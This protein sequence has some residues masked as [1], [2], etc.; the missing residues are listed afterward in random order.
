MYKYFQDQSHLLLV[1]ANFVEM[2]SDE[3][4]NGGSSEQLGQALDQTVKRILEKQ[5]KP[6][7]LTMVR[8]QVRSMVV[9]IFQQEIGP[10]VEDLIRRV[11]KEV[12]QEHVEVRPSN[13]GTRNDLPEE[14]SLQLKFVYDQVSD[15][16][17]GQELKGINNECL[18]LALV[19]SD[20]NIVTCGSGSDAK[21]EILLLDDNG[22][23]G[24]DNISLENFER[25]IIQTGEKK[26][27]HFAKSVYKSLKEGIAD[28]NDL[29]LGHDKDRIKK[30]SCRLGA[31]IM[32]NLDRTTVLEAWTA[33][34]T[35][36]DKHDKYNDK[37]PCPSL[38]S[39]V[40]RLEGIGRNGKPCD[41]LKNES[42]KTVQDFLFWFHVNPEKLQKKILCVGDCKWK[43]IVSHAQ[44][45]NIDCKR[46][47]SHKSSTEPQTCVIYD[48]VG[49]L[50]GSIVESHF[51]PIDDMPSDEKDR[52]RELLRYVLE[53]PSAFVE[54]YASSLEDEGSLLKKFPY[55]SLQ[56]SGLTVSEDMNGNHTSSSQS[57]IAANN[58]YACG[59][60]GS[61]GSIEMGE[62]SN[63][64]AFPTDLHTS[65]Y[66]T[67]LCFENN[68]SPINMLVSGND[69]HTAEMGGGSSSGRSN[70]SFQSARGQWADEEL[71]YPALLSPGQVLA[72]FNSHNA[73][74]WLW[75][76]EELPHCPGSPSSDPTLYH[77]ADVETHN[78]RAH[79]DETCG[80][81]LPKG[82]KKLS[83]IWSS[84]SKLMSGDAGPS[85][86]KGRVD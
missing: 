39:E 83:R 55:R 6:M 7:M 60:S 67:P 76:E 50:K 54:R 31:R 37:H 47:F 14:R 17:T 73:H 24:E 52:A 3:F 40:W 53:E 80:A 9:T 16:V 86:K 38:S 74:G 84:F 77:A 58:S 18:K 71:S 85:C 82:L 68:S 75:F 45:C 10:V 56:H 36:I 41:R 49:K 20:G 13:G 27:P 12:L 4:E 21:A 33:P 32:Q 57:I 35:V 48:A 64:C 26:K 1:V 51:V 43:T 72:D 29:K 70:A 63:S 62:L 79:E 44:K 30:Y 78:A 61:L 11:V 25:R 28:L 15:T 66:E 59:P 8:Q 42:I 23:G 22:D 34:F 2:D 81:D 65:D 5:I 46:M 19:D 69:K